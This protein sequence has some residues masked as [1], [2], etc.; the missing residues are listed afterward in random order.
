MST[1]THAPSGLPNDEHSLHLR[2]FDREVQVSWV[3]LTGIAVG[4]VTLV[5]FVFCWWGLVFMERIDRKHEVR[6]TPIEEVTPQGPAPL[7]ALQIAPQADMKTMRAEE[8]QR[9]ENPSWAD[10][11]QGT[12]N[13][14]IEDALD[15][16][17]RRGVAPLDGATAPAPMVAPDAAGAAV[18]TPEGAAVPA[19]P[20]GGGGL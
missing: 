19:S 8:A 12:V 2:G 17:V 10:R 6:V 3:L 9:L 15:A 11:S 7:P 5:S 1:E 16:V 20:P 13:L 18:P 14:K 4:L